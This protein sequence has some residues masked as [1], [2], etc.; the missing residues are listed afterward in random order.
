MCQTGIS[1]TWGSSK[2]MIELLSGDTMVMFF[3]HR[4]TRTSDD[5]YKNCGTDVMYM[6][7]ACQ[8]VERIITPINVS[9]VFGI[10]AGYPAI[11]L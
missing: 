5:Q 3:V 9:E 4:G 1:L 11:A 10:P 7:C 2:R 6:W 8:S